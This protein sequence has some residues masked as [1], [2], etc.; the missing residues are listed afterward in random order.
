MRCPTCAQNTPDSW[1]WLFVN[2]AGPHGPEVELAAPRESS[3]AVDWMHCANNDCKELV[4]RV[5]QSRLSFI[6][7]APVEVDTQTWT[8]RPR[9]GASRSVDPLVPEPYRSDFIEAAGIL[10]RSPRMSAV[11]SRSILADLLEQYAQKTHYNLADRIDSF[12]A[13]TSHPRR[14]RENLHYLREIADLSAHTKK[15][16]QAV[17]VAVEAAEAEWTLEVVERLFDYFIVSSA[18][19]AAIR[20]AVD[21]K[22]KDTARKPIKP[23]PDDRRS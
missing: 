13:D 21:Q 5:H 17:V 12:N 22:L 4:V 14:L 18:K 1:Q 9:D 10:N 7:S 15:N 20:D 2:H 11:L 19:D 8:A 3:V 16:D 6:G 23:L